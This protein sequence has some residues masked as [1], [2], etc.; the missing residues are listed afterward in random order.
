MT[1]RTATCACGRVQV[2]VEND[3]YRVVI[4]HC[5]FCQKRSGGVFAVTAHF[6][7]EQIVNTRGET[8]RYNGLEVDGVGGATE[9]GVNYHFCTTCGSTVFWDFDRSWQGPEWEGKR[10]VAVA[11]GNFADPKFP[12]PIVEFY[13]T[14]R[15]HW[16]SPLPNADQVET[17]RI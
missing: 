3:P 5:E 4:C 15:H 7:E 13:T 9:G 10:V 16:V 11:V 14:S 12:I 1:R 6:A 8:K 2:T 17:I